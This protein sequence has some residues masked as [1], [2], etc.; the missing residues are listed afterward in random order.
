MCS[1]NAISFRF[2]WLASSMA[3]FFFFQAEDGIRVLTVTGVQTCA[4]PPARPRHRLDRRWAG[5]P[6]RRA[7]I[8]AA[9]A[10]WGVPGAHSGVRE[11]R[12]PQRGRKTMWVPPNRPEAP[13][14]HLPECLYVIY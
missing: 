12:L 5:S 9:D 10:M 2:A 8:A 13:T 4:L 3:S 11:V 6:P 1:L 7:T 14:S